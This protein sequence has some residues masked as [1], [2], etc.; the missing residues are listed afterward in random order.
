VTSA[1]PSPTRA[2]DTFLARL[3]ARAVLPCRIGGSGS[4][5]MAGNN[6]TTLANR[7]FNRFIT[8]VQDAYPSGTGSESTPVASPAAVFGTVTNDPG[9]HGYNA[10]EGGTTSANYLTADERTAMASLDLALQLH[11]VGSNDYASGISTA[12]Y[13]ANLQG[14]LSDLRIKRTVPC[15][16]VLVHAHQRAD[17]PSP[18]EPWSAYGQVLSEVAAQYPDRTVFIDISGA[19][20]RN[21]VPDPDPLNLLDTDGIHLTDVGLDFLADRIVM[22]L[23]IPIVTG[24]NP[25]PA[26]PAVAKDTTAP[27]APSAVT[28]TNP[29]ASTVPLSWTAS[30]DAV[31]VTGYR[32]RRAGIVVG[33][34][35]GT[36][37]TDTGLAPATSYPY[38]VTAVDAAGNESTP[39]AEVTATTAAGTTGAVS[40]ATDDYNRPDST[41]LGTTATGA[42]RYLSS[43]TVSPVISGQRIGHTAAAGIGA[44]LVDTGRADV[45]IEATLA[46]IGTGPSTR[47]GGLAIR[48]TTAGNMYWLST[49]RDGGTDGFDLWQITNGSPTRLTFTKGG[50]L[51]TA[52]QRLR[53]TAVG[54]TITA[55]VDGL[56]VAQ[57]T[58]ATFNQTATLAGFAMGAQGLATRWDD[59]AITTT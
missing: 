30:T 19:F 32:V 56:Q 46:A 6:A 43:G 21:G 22:A 42:L 1:V 52:G 57:V 23:A 45:T 55:F 38:T 9:V 26:A 11:I 15:V 7:V 8:R 5:T 16:D 28:V 29:T 36:T 51:P 2:L 27:S 34:P 47:Q 10:G 37:F 13:R 58:T 48:A 25:A 35:T 4:S 44:V 31:G 33:T 50:V 24:R 17:V 18:A 53:V 54:S 41:T 14:V 39:S 3:S 59:L 40:I 20:A 12:A 49:R